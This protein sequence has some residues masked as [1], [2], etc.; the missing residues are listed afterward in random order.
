MSATR[1]AGDQG[2]AAQPSDREVGRHIEVLWALNS[3]AL[4]YLVPDDPV[5]WWDA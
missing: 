5:L 3:H 1:T 2:S 4:C